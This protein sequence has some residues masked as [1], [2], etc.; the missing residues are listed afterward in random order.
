MHVRGLSKHAAR[1]S[2][3]YEFHRRHSVPDHVTVLDKL[4]YA[5]NHASLEGLPADRLTFVEGDIADAELT[6]RIFAEQGIRAIM[7]FAGS[8]VVPE[9]VSDPLKYYLNNTVRTRALIE[10]AVKAER[11]GAASA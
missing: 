8:V 1:S 6:A 2:D 11:T 3:R 9:S 4:T 5:G 10:S 7:H